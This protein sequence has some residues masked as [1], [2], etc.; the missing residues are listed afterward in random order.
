MKKL[1]VLATFAL[2]VTAQ[3]DWTV[4]SLDPGNGSGGSGVGLVEVGYYATNGMH[5]VTWSGT[6]ASFTDIHPAGQSHSEALATRGNQIV[7][8]TQFLP[9]DHAA[10]WTNHVWRD[11]NPANASDSRAWATDG[12]SQVGYYAPPSGAHAC[13]WSGTPESVVDLNPAG[14]TSSVASGID[15]GKQVGYAQVGGHEHAFIWSGTPESAVDLN[16]Q[17][18]SGS[19][20]NA[21]SGAIQVGSAQFVYGVNHA[22]YWRGTAG[23]CVDINPQNGNVSSATGVVDDIIVGSFAINNGAPRAGMWKGPEATLVDLQAM[24]PSKYSNAAAKGISSDGATYLIVGTANNTETG[25]PEAIL[26]T[27]TRDTF[28]FTLNKTQVAGQ[29]SVQGTIT[30]EFLSASATTFTTYD[31]SSLVTTPPT[32]TV[33]AN[34]YLKNFQITVTAV[35][36]PI[37]TILYAKLGNVIKTQPL[38][39]VPLIPTALAFTP[40]PVLGGNEVSAKIVING[41]AGPGGRTIS[42]FDNSNYATTPKTVIVPAGASSVTFPIQTTHPATGQNVTVTARVSAGE[43]TG[44]FRINP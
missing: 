30:R 28:N 35:N 26:W 24:L 12:V 32:V 15:G 8:Y 40:N 34:A 11:L 39:L 19:K 31:N 3:A 10:L 1:A 36:S 13:M 41:V 42:V 5:A 29:N 20:V 9:V 21:I 38:T 33:P 23:S 14:A 16:P 22:V 17:G 25:L 37:N 6:A 2:A 4:V 27:V 43:K 18:A 7:G 44:T